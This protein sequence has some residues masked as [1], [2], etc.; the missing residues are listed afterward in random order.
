MF[1]FFYLVSTASRRRYSSGLCRRP[2]HLQSKLGDVLLQIKIL[3]HVCRRTRYRLV[4]LFQV[5]LSSGSQDFMS[6]QWKRIQVRAVTLQNLDRVDSNSALGWSPRID[7]NLCLLCLCNR[8]QTCRRCPASKKVEVQV[9]AGV[10]T[11]DWSTRVEQLTSVSQ[12]DTSL[13][14]DSPRMVCPKSTQGLC[15]NGESRGKNNQPADIPVTNSIE[16]ERVKFPTEGSCI[17]PG[18][19]RPIQGLTQ[20]WKHYDMQR[21]QALGDRI[22]LST[23]LNGSLDVFAILSLVQP[24]YKVDRSNHGRPIGKGVPKTTY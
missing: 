13:F 12:K 20:G 1:F 2:A 24:K 8:V 6:S 3:L 19:S 15:P 4:L 5:D 11:C 14:H 7:T 10:G 22:S 9:E 23:K 21:D 16:R 18:P 17:C